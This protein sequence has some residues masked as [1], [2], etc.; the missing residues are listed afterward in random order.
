MYEILSFVLTS[1]ASLEVGTK[2]NGYLRLR[3]MIWEK[4]EALLHFVFVA[5]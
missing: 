5:D 3:A 2:K 4:K 1:F